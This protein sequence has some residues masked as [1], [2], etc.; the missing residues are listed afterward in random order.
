MCDGSQNRFWIIGSGQVCWEYLNLVYNLETYC[1]RVESLPAI[2]PEKLQEWLAP[3]IEELDITFDKPRLDKQL[4]DGDKDNQDHYFQILEDISQGVSIVA[5]QGF[6]K[7]IHYEAVD[8]EDETQPKPEILVAQTPRLGKLPLLESADHYLLY[9][10][11]L[12]EDMTLSA[13]AESLGDD[14]AEVQ[15]RVQVLLSNTLLITAIAPLRS[16]P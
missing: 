14:E 3:I 4:L 10:L 7:S 11:L 15:A 2:A 13:L 16:S 8:Q 6:L 12:H 1:G 9:S 5:V